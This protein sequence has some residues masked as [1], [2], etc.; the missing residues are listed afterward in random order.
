MHSAE[1]ADFSEKRILFSFPSASRTLAASVAGRLRNL[2]SK[3][4]C[5][6]LALL[7]KTIPPVLSASR[8]VLY[9]IEVIQQPPGNQ[10]LIIKLIGELSC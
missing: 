8:S 1:Q 9:S 4:Q 2:R 6:Y 5:D 10:S 3:N 7:Y